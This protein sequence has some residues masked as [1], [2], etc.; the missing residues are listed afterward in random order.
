[1]GIEVATFLGTLEDVSICIS[2]FIIVLSL[3]F[4]VIINFLI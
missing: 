3:F 2:F 1:M 4:I